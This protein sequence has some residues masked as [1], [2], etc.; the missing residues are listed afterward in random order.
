MT[1]NEKTHLITAIVKNESGVLTRISGLFARRCFNIDS[2]AVCGTEQPE[3][4]RMTIVSHGDDA[5]LEQIILQLGKLVDVMSVS[6]LDPN[7]T[8]QRE[9]CLIKIAVSGEKLPEI[10][11]VCHT[12]DAK[13]VDL[14]PQS[15]VLELTGKPS[16][17]NGFIEVLKPYGI[18]EL[19]RTGIISLSRGRDLT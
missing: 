6:D 4:S 16:K 18:L 14:S 10:E 1:K 3:L 13:T 19:S 5:S 12:Y 2:L 11:S 8:V 7:N 9:L 15:M 17:V